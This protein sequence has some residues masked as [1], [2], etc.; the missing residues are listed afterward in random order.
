MSINLK[1]GQRISLT[2]DNQ[3]LSKIM[4]GL[5]WDPV[6]KGSGGLLGALFGGGAPDID[7]DASVLMLDANDK[8]K[9]KNDIIY[10]GNLTS[11]C[12]SVRHMGDNLTGEG[13]GDDEQIMIDLNKVPANIQKLVF[14][15]NIYDCVRRKQDFGM[16]Q[17][18]FIRIVN[19]ANNQELVRFNLTEQYSGRTALF[20]GEIYRHNN[21][22]KFA[23]IGEG[24]NDTSLK[25]IV[26]RFA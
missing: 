7:C 9:D 18:A 3:G 23:A 26:Q 19:M 10:F 13:E 22:W 6:K 12:G 4:V 25:D 21:E 1:K 11:K 20:V 2:K 14:V 8:I 17:N 16:I 15:V 24:T 5:G